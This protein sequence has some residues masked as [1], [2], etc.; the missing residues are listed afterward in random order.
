MLFLQRYRH[1]V[2][3]YIDEAHVFVERSSRIFPWKRVHLTQNNYRRVVTSNPMLYTKSINNTT[4]FE[5]VERNVSLI[6]SK[7]GVY[8][9]TDLLTV[10]SQQYSLPEFHDNP[11]SLSPTCNVY[12]IKNIGN[13][14]NLRLKLIR[15]SKFIKFR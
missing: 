5:I 9:C 15:F 6:E 2:W 3:L 8:I 14:S 10:N 4:Q 7:S 1:K 12:P 11:L 13:S